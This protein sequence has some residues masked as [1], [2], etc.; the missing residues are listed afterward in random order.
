MSGLSAD[1]VIEASRHDKKMDAGKIRFILLKQ[2]GEA[3]V[4]ETV[5]AQEMAEALEFVLK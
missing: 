4:D 2:V 5:T 1:A 3:C